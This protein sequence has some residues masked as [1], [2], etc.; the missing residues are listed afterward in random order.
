MVAWRRTSSQC[1]SNLLTRGDLSKLR[2]L[3]DLAAAAL[4]QK[5]EVMTMPHFELRQK[6]LMVKTY[7]PCWQGRAGHATH[8]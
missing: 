5:R 6:I 8:R 2:Q 1:V 3:L 7:I 4:K